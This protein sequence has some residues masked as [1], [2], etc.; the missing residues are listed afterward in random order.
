MEL[1]PV[2]PSSPSAEFRD[3]WNASHHGTDIFAPRGA[4][5]LACDDGRV[6]AADERKGG[7]VVYLH[8]TDGTTYFYGHLDER[9]GEFPRD[10]VAG[11]QIGTV[12]NSGN[13]MGKETHVHFEVHVPG[14]GA[15]DPYPLL[16][17]AARESGATPLG[18]PSSSPSSSSSSPGLSSSSSKAGGGFALLVLLALFLMRRRHG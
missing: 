10:V 1:F 17:S 14:S 12:G 16:A 8:A 7:T 4:P 5:V 9:T 11:D 13:A 18:A 6:T 3:A 2:G 15:V